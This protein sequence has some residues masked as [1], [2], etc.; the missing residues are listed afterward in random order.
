MPDRR[1]LPDPPAG[2]V[3]LVERRASLDVG[4]EEDPLR[5]ARPR[6]VVDPVVEALGEDAGLPAGPVEKG[7]AEAV[8]LVAGNLLRP[9]GQVASVRRVARGPVPG[10]VRLGEVPRRGESLGRAL[11]GDRPH[12]GVGRGLGV[13]DA[14]RGEGE[15]LSVRGEGEPPGAGEGED[16]R[17]ERARRQVPE[18][19]AREV[20]DEDAL[21]HL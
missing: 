13:G 3:Q 5:V 20:E 8:G 9:P 16:R 15:L 2:D 10:R 18:L 6:E 14:L 21:Y 12:V 19:S 17:L 7:E 11:D 1:H 4:G